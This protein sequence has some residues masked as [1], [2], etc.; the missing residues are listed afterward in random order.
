MSNEMVFHYNYSA[1]QNKEVLDI[2]NKYLPKT[3]SKLDELKR[4]DH[5]VQNAG[6]AHAL[7]VGI[8]GCLVFGLGLCLAM[9]VIG[10]SI[11]LGVLLGIIGTVAMCFAYPVYRKIFGREKEKYLPRILELAA[12]LSGEQDVQKTEN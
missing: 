8:L 1:V 7:V 6:M 2:R 12:Q 4:L 5:L 3:E 11:V 9:Q 10:H